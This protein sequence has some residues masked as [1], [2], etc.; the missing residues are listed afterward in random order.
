M[1]HQTRHEG[2]EGHEGPEDHERHE[3][4]DVLRNAGWR[5]RSLPGFAGLIGPIWTRKEETGWRYGLL[6]TDA[7]TNP[8]GLV[9]GGLISTLLDH[10]LSAIAWESVGR[11]PCVTVQL[12]TKFVSAARSGDL[13][14]VEGSVVRATSSL[15]FLVGNLRAGEEDI[16][17]ASAVLKILG[18]ARAKT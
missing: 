9:H 14:V 8:A 11:L 2:H 16:A 17:F 1:N 15:V 3:R 6:A 13:L 7:H 12:D 10:A 18:A 5:E 4:H